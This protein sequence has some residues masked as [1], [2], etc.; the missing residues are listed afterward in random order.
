VDSPQPIGEI[1]MSVQMIELE[2]VTMMNVCDEALEGSI[3][4]YG[5]PSLGGPDAC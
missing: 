2:E 1:N 4:S 3:M 5:L